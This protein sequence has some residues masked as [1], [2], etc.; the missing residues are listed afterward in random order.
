MRVNNI[1]FISAGLI[2]LSA[3]AASCA[4]EAGQ[5]RQFY[6]KVVGLQPNDANANFDLGNIYLQDKRYEEALKCYDKAGKI[7]LALSRMDSY[8]FNLS[9][10]YAGLNRM[11]DAISSLEK[12][13]KINPA[14]KDA[15]DLLAL[16][17]DKSS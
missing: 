9:V 17:K 1:V 2:L 12:C 13:V 11:S 6:E 10:C 8:Y 3:A 7:G 16:Y 4:E 15:K 5:A 14:Y